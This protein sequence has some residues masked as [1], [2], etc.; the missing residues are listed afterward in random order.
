[1]RLA[2]GT[3]DINPSFTLQIARRSMKY[4]LTSGWYFILYDI[5]EKNPALASQ[6]YLELLN[7]YRNSDIFRLLY[8]SAFPFANS[9]IIGAEKFSFGSGVPANLQAN[10]S[11]Q[12]QY[13]TI[14]FNRLLQLSPENNTVSPN[15]YLSEKIISIYA[16][17]EIESSLIADFPELV[18]LFNRTKIHVLSSVSNDDIEKTAK[19]KNFNDSASKTF[20]ERLEELKKD[21][22]EGKL[23]DTKIVQLLISAKTKEDFDLGENWLDKIQ[24]ETSK[25]QTVNYFYFSRAMLDV[26]E[27]RFDEA[28]KNAQRIEKIE[29]KAII[30][31]ELAE[32]VYNETKNKIEAMDE[33]LE[34]EKLANKSPDS[35]AKAQIYLGLANIYVKFDKFN[36]L[37]ALSK[38]T[39][40]VNKLEYEN[41]FD[42]FF[43]RSIKTENFSFFAGY[44]LPGFDLS[45][46]FYEFSKIDFQ[47]SLT[48][49]Q[50]FNNKYYE[51]LATLA[52]VKDCEKNIKTV[53]KKNPTKK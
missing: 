48:Y 11:L 43:T 29:D 21:E 13:L 27:K 44:S 12:R 16:V 53:P 26:K 25:A 39:I 5:A 24:N 50:S 15:S 2:A 37:D 47:N 3:S 38:T 33:I 20:A 49:A 10:I 30:Y 45:N 14:L 8:L 40:V 42:S 18:Q 35:V 31:F 34:A 28:R 51:S 46:V 17:N 9:R 52:T 22:G 6:I 7:N 36:A 32:A 41:I 19:R 1:L 4:D 23:T